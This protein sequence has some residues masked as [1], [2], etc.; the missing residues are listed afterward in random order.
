MAPSWNGE[1]A[2]GY[3][4][5]TVIFFWTGKVCEVSKD[6]FL[7]AFLW[8][9]DDLGSGRCRGGGCNVFFLAVASPISLCASKVTYLSRPFLERSR[10][11]AKAS[12]HVR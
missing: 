10:G 8:L 1:V 5:E 7:S 9:M 2:Q 11:K 12:S 3:W 6:D 4:R